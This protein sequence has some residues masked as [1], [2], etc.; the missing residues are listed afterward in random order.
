MNC[1][2]HPRR[3]SISVDEPGIPPLCKQC[4]DSVGLPVKSG[5]RV[6]DTVGHPACDGTIAAFADDSIAIV[7]SDDGG[8]AYLPVALL[9]KRRK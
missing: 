2:N 8:V 6:I 3:V 9:V 4:W 7:D 1:L 5:D